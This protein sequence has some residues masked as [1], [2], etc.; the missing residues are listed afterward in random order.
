MIAF[1]KC[2]KL[3]VLVGGKHRKKWHWTWKMICFSCW[4]L[5]WDAAKRSPFGTVYQMHSSAKIAVASM[6]F[7][8]FRLGV[9]ARNPWHI[10]ASSQIQQFF[11]DDLHIAMENPPF[12]LGKSTISMAIFNSYVSLPEGKHQNSWDVHHLHPKK[13]WHHCFLMFF[14]PRTGKWPGEYK[15]Y[16][17][18][19][20]SASSTCW[21]ATTYRRWIPYIWSILIAAQDW[22]RERSNQWMMAWYLTI[23]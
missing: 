6:I 9:V 1:R 4:S 23:W 15:G 21:V 18:V 14:D 12:L 3:L 22:E 8:P 2:S 20:S 17:P 7:R 19:S 11:Q 16:T 10:L 5:S 13:I